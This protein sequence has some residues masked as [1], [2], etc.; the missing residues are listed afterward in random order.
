MA[1]IGAEEDVLKIRNPL[2]KLIITKAIHKAIKNKFGINALIS[3][4]DLGISTN[5]DGSVFIDVQASANLAPGTLNTIAAMIKD[6][7]GDATM[8]GL[9]NA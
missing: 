4:K 9:K 1:E 6:D 8:K 2:T 5:P 7:T 3:I